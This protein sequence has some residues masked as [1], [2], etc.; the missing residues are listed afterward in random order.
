MAGITIKSFGGIS[1]KVPARYLAD[2]QAQVAVNAATLNTS[3][4]PIPGLGSTVTTLPLAD[5]PKTIYR[6]GQDVD[7]EFNYWFAWPFDVDVC[8]GQIAGDPIE[9]TFYTGDG[10]PKATN[11]TLAISSPPYPSGSVP[12]GIPAP[13]VALSASPDPTFDS[14]AD[15][16]AELTLGIVALSAL[17]EDGIEISLDN[18]ET[19]MVVELPDLPETNRAPYVIATLQAAITAETLTGVT[20]EKSELDPNGVLIKTVATGKT[21]TLHF[22]GRV[23]DKVEYD[24][25]G[26]FTYNSLNFSDTGSTKTPPIY[27][28]LQSQWAS[29]GSP[30]GDRVRIRATDAS[31][32]L[33]VVIDGV[34]TTPF[35]NA[36]EVVTWLKQ[37]WVVGYTDAVNITS[38]GTTVVI[39]A[40]SVYGQPTADKGG[41]IEYILN[42]FDKEEKLLRAQGSASSADNARVFITKP[43]FEN[44]LQ[45]K[46][47][48]TSVDGKSEEK[49]QIAENSTALTLN[50]IPG[51]T[52]RYIGDEDSAFAIETLTTGVSSSITIRGGV[53]PTSSEFAYFKLYAV[54]YEDTSSVPESRV[55]TYSWVSNLSNFEFESGPAPASSSVDVFVGQ[56][57]ELSGFEPVPAD[58]TYTYTARRI[59]R[60][61]SGVYL[62]VDEIPATQTSYTDTKESADLAEEMIITGWKEPPPNLRGLINLP[63]G[64]MAGFVGR[65]VYLCDPYHPHA[66]PESYVQTIDFPIVGLGRMDTTLAVLTKGVPYFI[67]GSHPDS[68]VVVKSDLQQACVSKRSIVSSNGVVIYASPD[69]LV[70]LSSGGSKILTQDLFSRDQWQ[71]INPE[72]IH[73][74]EHDLKYVAFYSKETV[75]PDTDVTTIVSGGFIYDFLTNQFVFHDIY[76]EAGYSDKQFDRLFLTSSDNLLKGWQE[77]TAKNYTWK[78]KKFTLPKPLSF[79]CAQVE[80]ESYPVTAKFYAD[81][82]LFL[83][84]TVTS[85]EVFRLPVVVARDY[86][87]QFEGNKEIFSFAMAQSVEELKNA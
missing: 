57:V 41:I 44:Y 64:I 35:T 70:M 34:R 75:D 66:W 54:G 68:M 13:V 77:G 87:I 26:A 71:S 17:T 19:Y 32:S 10:I 6:F 47:A 14:S 76:V 67:Q 51:V 11:T 2:N 27:Y 23:G 56:S 72:S 39:Q 74:Y 53:Y 43:D 63:N 37:N 21:V 15:Y 52:V 4:Q 5:I 48:A 3:L 40:G 1:P 61:V 18:E 9:W 83:T 42:K 28:L 65:D 84:K 85:R 33:K 69:G 24:L 29:V 12:L 78:S 36:A 22:R 80:A 58:T 38:Y 50:F 55:Y 16:P 20:V 45:G 60:S 73:A 81:G 25:Q 31:N 8:R 49:T 79:N 59:Y 30:V 86:E 7:N 82:T 62:F 46:F